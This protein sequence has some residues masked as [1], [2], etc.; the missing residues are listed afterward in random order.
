MRS[1]GVKYYLDK[2]LNNSINANMGND[3]S[4]SNKR[5]RVS[6]SPQHRFKANKGTRGMPWRQVPK[7]DVVHCEKRG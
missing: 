1:D 7:K 4:K 6:S 3:E 5:A 2:H